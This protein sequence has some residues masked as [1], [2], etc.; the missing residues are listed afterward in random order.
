MDADSV[1]SLVVKGVE[2]ALLLS[3]PF[4]GISLVT[5]VI[6]SLLQA[7]TQVQEQTLTFVP[8]LLI[9]MLVLVLALPWAIDYMGTY[10]RD[11][12]TAMAEI[13]P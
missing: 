3:L 5:G 8:K 11:L 9:I 2:V 6:I 12:F 1:Q 10:M 4:L 7:V 13:R